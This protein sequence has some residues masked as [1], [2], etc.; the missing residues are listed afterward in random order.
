M[1]TFDFVNRANADY[2]DQ[3]FRQYKNDPAS[4]PDQWQAYFSGFEMGSGRTDLTSLQTDGATAAAPASPASD[5]E[6]RAG[7]FDL[8][9]TYREMGHYT[10][11]STRSTS[12]SGR[13]T[14]CST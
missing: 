11:S 12:S 1:Q 8:V 5:P 7:I 6:F 10:P 14:R 4:V 13:C 9:H 2:I 3:L